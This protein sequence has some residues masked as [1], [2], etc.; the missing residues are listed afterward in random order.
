M[1]IQIALRKR[2]FDFKRSEEVLS[3]LK[4]GSLGA[5]EREKPKLDMRT[6]KG[7]KYLAPLTTVGNLPF[8][9]LCVGLGAEITC[10][11]M[12]LATSLLSGTPSEYSLVKRHPCEKIFGVQLAGGFADTMTKAAQILVDEMTVSTFSTYCRHFS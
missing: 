3:A 4:E 11:E 5:M 9:R 12:A 10:G 8:R 1:H 7:K 6:L 2:T